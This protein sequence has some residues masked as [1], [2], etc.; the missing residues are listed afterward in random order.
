[1]NENILLVE[2]DGE[3]LMESSYFIEAIKNVAKECV[4]KWLREG[5]ITEEGKVKILSN[6]DENVWNL[7]PE[8]F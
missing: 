4:E 8:D 6:I 1:M 5:K 3:F 7:L 2:S